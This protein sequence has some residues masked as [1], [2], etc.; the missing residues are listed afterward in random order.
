MEQ[1]DID[2]A[3][4]WEALL[5]QTMFD[6]WTGCYKP[7]VIARNR[8][9]GANFCKFGPVTRS[10]RA[11]ETCDELL[12]TAEKKISYTLFRVLVAVRLDSVSIDIRNRNPPLEDLSSAADARPP[13]RI[14]AAKIPLRWHNE[15][16]GS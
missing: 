7:R 12:S 13:R 15:G 10:R 6:G 1:Y 2:K 5:S 11:A 9:L 8:D 14:A 4:H 16:C 3:E